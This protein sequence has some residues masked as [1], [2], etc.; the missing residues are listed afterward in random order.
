MESDKKRKVRKGAVDKIIT[1]IKLII[2]WH[3]IDKKNK[4]YKV[5][6]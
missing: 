1:I 5:S 4:K 6:N 2:A 3:F